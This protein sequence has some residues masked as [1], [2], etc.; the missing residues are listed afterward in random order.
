MERWIVVGNS[1]LL[2]SADTEAGAVE[3]GRSY[4]TANGG[5]VEIAR[6][7]GEVRPAEPVYYQPKAGGA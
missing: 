4:V 3:I 6:V 5:R 7:V 2:G 1:R